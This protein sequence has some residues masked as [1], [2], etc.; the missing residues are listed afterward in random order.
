MCAYLVDFTDVEYKTL[1][2]GY[3]MM[4]FNIANYLLDPDLG[5]SAYDKYCGIY[6]NHELIDVTESKSGGYDLV[7][8]TNLEN[9]SK[10]VVKAKKIILAMPKRSI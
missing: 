9:N 1:Q 7:F 4:N 5:L 10:R 6:L 2:G 8:K 3:D